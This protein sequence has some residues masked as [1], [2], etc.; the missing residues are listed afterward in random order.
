MIIFANELKAALLCAATNDLRQY[1]NAVHIRKENGSLYVESSDGSIIFQ[2]RRPCGDQG[3]LSL[4]IPKEIIAAFLSMKK[5]DCALTKKGDSW[6][7]GGFG[8]DPIQG[9]FPD[10]GRYFENRKTPEG[11]VHFTWAQL[12][13]KYLVSA[14]N[15]MRLVTGLKKGKHF[16]LQFAESGAL[17]YS[18]QLAHPMCFIAPLRFKEY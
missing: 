4:L 10:V 2:N 8:F 13:P 18:P 16:P 1:L 15:A 11:S 5:K 17:M 14:D 9:V 12:S 7:L 3:P 6:D